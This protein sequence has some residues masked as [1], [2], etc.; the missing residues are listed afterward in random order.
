MKVT[1]KKPAATASATPAEDAAVSK[2]KKIKIASPADYIRTMPI[3]L[4]GPPGSGKTF[5]MLSA[6]EFWPAD[7]K[8]HR[9]TGKMLTLEDVLYV[10]IDPAGIVGLAEWLI[11][12]KHIVDIDSEVGDDEY[13]NAA[14]I[15]ADAVDEAMNKHK[16]AFVVFDTASMFSSK[17]QDR[18][19][20]LIEDNEAKKPELYNRQ[21]RAHGEFLAVTNH[22]VTRKGAMPIVGFHVRKESSIFESDAEKAHKAMIRGREAG[23]GIIDIKGQAAELMMSSFRELW[24]MRSTEAVSGKT[25][26]T[27]RQIYTG[28]QGFQCKSSFRRALPPFVGHPANMR[29]L[30]QTIM[31]STSPA[32]EAA[33]PATDA[34]YESA[35][36]DDE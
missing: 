5:A 20:R 1:A 16:P 13:E 18:Y 21:K 12:P 27:T 6:S 22:L 17:I 14:R 26:V 19:S 8:A 35:T 9:A 15:M 31:A 32:A 4:A 28:V 2:P 30:I 23:Q 24:F 25:V 34:D 11:Q 36:A 29:K 10:N 33:T 3:G 7:L